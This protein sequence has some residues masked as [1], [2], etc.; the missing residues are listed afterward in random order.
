MH[1]LKSMQK[2]W[3]IP[4]FEDVSAH[5]DD[6]IRPH[7]DQLLIEGSVMEL[8]ERER[9]GDFRFSRW[10]RV[11]NDMRRVEEF[12]V[13]Q[14]AQRTALSIRSK[15]A[16]PELFLVYPADRRHFDIAPSEFALCRRIR[17]LDW[18]VSSIEIDVKRE[19]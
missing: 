17:N 12:S 3:A 15:N 5:F 16:P 2:H 19:R 8:A 9:V 4:F 7:A 11:R 10:I 6:E 14:A 18:K 1:L 13:P